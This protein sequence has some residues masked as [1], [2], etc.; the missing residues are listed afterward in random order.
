MLPM[1]REVQVDDAIDKVT[2]KISGT[3][4]TPVSFA[5]DKNTDVGLVQFAMKTEA[6]AV[7][8]KEKEEEPRT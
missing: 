8:E 1:Q 7:K 2:E 5:S 6:I 4:F 3:D